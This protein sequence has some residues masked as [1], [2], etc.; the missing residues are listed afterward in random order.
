MVQG[1]AWG[2]GSCDGVAA[3]ALSDLL[4]QAHALGGNGV[5]DVKFRA[6][7]HWTGH[8]LC[9]RFLPLLPGAYS[10][11]VQGLAVAMP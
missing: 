11:D 1:S 8:A 5:E 3:R 6:R 2:V 9:K 4:A 10:V 7:W